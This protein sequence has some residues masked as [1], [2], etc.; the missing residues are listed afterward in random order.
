MSIQKRLSQLVRM[1]Q[2]LNAINDVISKLR[3]KIEYRSPQYSDMPKATSNRDN[4]EDIIKIIKLENDYDY[5]TN[6]YID[7]QRELIKMIYRLE[8]NAER[9]ILIKRYIVGESWEN[10]SKS[11]NYSR[12][13]SWRIHNRGIRKLEK[14]L[15]NVT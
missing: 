1:N 15:Q 13:Q 8:D 9:V 14:M 10:I 7:Y 6:K 12:Q 2:E 3:R 4:Q 5:L 11:M